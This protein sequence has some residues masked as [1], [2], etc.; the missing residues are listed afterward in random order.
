M[1]FVLNIILIGLSLLF[2]N[3][4]TFSQCGNT[5][6]NGTNAHCDTCNAEGRCAGDPFDPFTGNESRTIKDLQV[7]GGVGEHQLNFTRY[8]NSRDSKIKN[9]FGSAH[10]WSFSYDFSMFYNGVSREG[11][12]KLIVYY[13]EGGSN[14]FTQASYDSTWWLSVSGVKNHLFRDGN[15]FYLKRPNGFRYRFEKLTS[16]KGDYFRLQDFKDSHQNLYTLKYDDNNRLIQIKEPAGRYLQIN[17][18]TVNSNANIITDVSTNDGRSVHY[19]YDVYTESL[20]SWVRLIAVNY[21]DNSKAVYTYSQ[22]EPGARPLLEHAID[23]RSELHGTNMIYKY[24]NSITNGYIKEERNGVTGEVMATLSASYNDRRVCYANGRTEHYFMPANLDGRLKE[25]TDGLGR[26]TVYNFDFG[27]GGTG[28]IKGETDAMG[29]TTYHKKT[30][31][32]NLLETTYPDGSTESWTRDNLDRILTHTDELGRKTTYTRDDQH[33]V[34]KTTYADGTAEQYTYNSFGQ[35]LTHT[36]QNGGIEHYSYDSRGLRTSVTDALGN[37][38]TYTYD[39]ASRLASVTDARGNTARYEYSERGLITKQVNADNSSQ[40]YAYDDFGNLTSGTNEIGNTWITQYDEFRRITSL[41]DP[42]NRVTKYS[43]DLGGVCGCAHDNNTPTQITSPSGKITKMEYDVEW[44]LLRRT[45]GAGT[46]DAATTSFEYD[47]VGNLVNRIDPKGKQWSYKYD[48]RNQQTS[49][50]DPLGNETVTTYDAAGNVIT[51]KGPDNGT[52]TNQYDNMNRV[53]M[54]TDQKGQVTKMDYDAEGNITKLTDA[55]NQV[56]GFT[57]DILDRQTKKSYPDGLSES[58][59]YDAAG[60]LQTYTAKAGQTASYVYDNMD[61]ET[62]MSWTSP[63]WNDNTPATNFTY[64]AAGRLLTM[65]SSVSA[66]TYT[67]NAVNEQTSETQDIAGAG[68]GGAKNVS[69]NY[70]ADGLLNR[71]VYPGGSRVRYNYTGRNQVSS[72]L[73]NGSDLVTYTYDKN[74]NRASK[75]LRNGTNTAYTYDDADQVLSIDNRRGS[76]SFGKFE[77]GYDNMDRM[78]FVKRNNGKGDAYSYDA[79][80]QITK[81]QYAVSNPE[82]TPANPSVTINYDFD[83][84][85]NRTNV[86]TNGAATG[87]TTN[88]M[89][90]YTNVGSNTLTYYDNA[91]LKTFNGWIYTYDA[92][93]RLTKA[94]KSDTIADFAYDAVNRCVKRTINGTAT[95]LYYDTW[96]LIEERNTSDSLIANYVHGAM[97]DEIL[98]RTA[99]NQVI[100]YHHDAVG[101]VVQITDSTGAV[102]ERYNYSVYGEF[103]IRNASGSSIASSAF[104]NRFMFTGR[105]FIQEIGLYDYRNRMYSQTLGRFLQSDPISF[106]GGDINLYRY[107]GNNPVNAIDP[108]G[109]DGFWAGVARGA[110]VVKDFFTGGGGGGSNNITT[111]INIGRGQQLTN[112]GSGPQQ[113]VINPPAGSSTTMTTRTTTTTTS[114]GVTTTT[115]TSTTTVAPPRPTPR[116]TPRPRPRNAS[117]SGTNSNTCEGA[118]QG[119]NPLQVDDIYH[120]GPMQ[121]DTMLI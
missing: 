89:N 101:N 95:F 115:T 108:F 94:Q 98:N 87:Y 82:V 45:E 109:L 34:T 78:K 76:A 107:V 64:D 119:E 3:T 51:V 92:Q 29:R 72:I 116:P 40:T 102:V 75:A 66:L 111:P 47:L 55:K 105:E 74:G 117:F 91:N 57:Y 70:N 10:R 99:G 25:Y 62:K 46:S 118:T 24:D 86:S 112:T 19:S 110:G 48:V 20:R 83:A 26:K 37:V 27:K 35:V 121:D 106:L 53:T 6:R 13:P 4:S 79:T 97:T 23:P 14:I 38:T 80:S 93:N 104:G 36:F 8:G 60:N 84:V 5:N 17:Y 88:N 21:G 54:T 41:K 120:G 85:G 81:V 100:Y 68:G 69:Y 18:G 39:N 65:V 33:R 59:T 32:G 58:Y 7:W 15:N 113:V 61:R 42:L 103:L 28:F 49:T 71:T 2:I 52:T 12:P 43:Y 56:Y 16:S 44:K 30:K 9:Y 11:Q 50:P 63:F 90:Q 73:L 77:Y 22:S 67:Y 96:N 1:K 114:N 31:Y